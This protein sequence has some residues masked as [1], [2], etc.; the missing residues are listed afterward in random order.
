MERMLSR[1]DEQTSRAY[2]GFTVYLWLVTTFG[3]LNS[4]LTGCAGCVL[5]FQ[6]VAHRDAP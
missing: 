1:M 2:H 4:I 3:L 6:H 5:P